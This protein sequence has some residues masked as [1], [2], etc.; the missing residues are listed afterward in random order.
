MQEPTFLKEIHENQIKAHQERVKKGISL[1]EYM[2]TIEQKEEETVKRL[3]LKKV[4]K[5]DM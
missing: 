1:N 2:K 4:V 3:G 5:S